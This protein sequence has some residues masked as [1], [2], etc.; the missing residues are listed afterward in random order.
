MHLYFRVLN[1]NK[2]FCSHALLFLGTNYSILN[3]FYWYLISVCII[4][5]QNIPSILIIFFELSSSIWVE[6]MAH[7]LVSFWPKNRADLKAWTEVPSTPSQSTASQAWAEL[8]KAK[9]LSSV[10][11]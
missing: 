4:N 2:I 8:G 9:S 10:G 6:L 11:N 5:N 1:N 3:N 7:P